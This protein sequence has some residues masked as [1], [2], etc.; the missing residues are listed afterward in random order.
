MGKSDTDPELEALLNLNGYRYYNREDGFWIKLEIVEVTPT[1]QRPHG[2]KY[3][4]TLHDR[5]GTRIIGF[6]N[7]HTV[8]LPGRK[9]YGG[10]KITYDHRHRLEKIL[11]YEFESPA[12]L[13]ED[14]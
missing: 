6:D 1:E 10:R 4:L 11:D 9:R 13:L 5:N 7:A 8:R 2:I 14:F 3:S 12:Q